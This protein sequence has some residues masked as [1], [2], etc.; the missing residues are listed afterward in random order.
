[1]GAHF[2]RSQGFDQE[3]AQV[4]PEEQV[5][6][7]R[8][9]PASLD[10]PQR[11]QNTAQSQN[12][13]KLNQF[14]IQHSISVPIVLTS[15]HAILT[16]MA[17][18]MVS[19]EDNQELMKAFMALDADGNGILS[20]EE[21]ITGYKSIYSDLENEKIEEIVE[22]MLSQVDANQEGNFGLI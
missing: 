16:F 12:I 2:G 18:Q 6:C 21:L 13:Q 20:R 1:V 22:D 15:S 3:H 19:R 8:G 5:L 17:S 9:S 7:S 11:A 10:H 14:P 4:Q